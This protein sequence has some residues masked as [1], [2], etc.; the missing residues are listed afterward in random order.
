[1]VDVTEEAQ[2]DDRQAVA[3]IAANQHDRLA[4]VRPPTQR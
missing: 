4:E 2:M 3:Q 1:V